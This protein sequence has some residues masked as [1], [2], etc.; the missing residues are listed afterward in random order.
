MENVRKHEI[1][2]VTLKARSNYLA[3]ETNIIQHTIK[4]DEI[5]R[6]IHEKPI[7]LG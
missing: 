3:S 1:K 5:S 7:Y 4:L 2:L 6:R